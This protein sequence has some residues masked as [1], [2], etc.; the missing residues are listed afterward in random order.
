MCIKIKVANESHIDTIS[1]IYVS[2]W[3]KAFKKFLLI[4][5]INKL[6]ISEKQHIFKDLI[7]EKQGEI[8]IAQHTKSK[9]IVG[10]IILKKMFIYNGEIVSFYINSTYKNVAES[11][12]KYLKVYCLKNNI[13]RVFL[14]TFRNN[15]NGIKFYKNIGFFESGLERESLIEVG[16]I[17]V[18]YIKKM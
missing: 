4:S 3:K 2:S 7:K 6:D 14:W 12:L 1:E 15:T 8:F 13:Q 9:E 10:Y 16:Q 11:L 17:E 5:T 18:Q